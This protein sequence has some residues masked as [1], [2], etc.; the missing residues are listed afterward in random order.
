MEKLKSKDSQGARGGMQK[1]DLPYIKLTVNIQQLEEIATGIRINGHTKGKRSPVR[2]NTHR[3][4]YI[5][6]LASQ[7]SRGIHSFI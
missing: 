3:V 7:I 4:S 2:I 6:K 5:T 1:L